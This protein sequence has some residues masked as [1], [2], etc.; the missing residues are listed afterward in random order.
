MYDF[1]EARSFLYSPVLE[2]SMAEC[3]MAVDGHSLVCRLR[4]ADPLLFKKTTWASLLQ[5]GL[6]HL[7]GLTLG[8][9]DE[10]SFFKKFT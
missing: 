9:F 1:C 8:L 7:T 10:N 2:C 5:A 4:R 6:Y 3:S